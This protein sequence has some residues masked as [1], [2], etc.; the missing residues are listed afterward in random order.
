MEREGRE[1]VIENP[2]I[3]HPIHDEVIRL[4]KNELRRHNYESCLDVGSGNCVLAYRL[5][6][7]KI[8]PKIH[9]VDV[10]DIPKQFKNCSEFEHIK[11]DLNKSFLTIRIK[12]KFKLILCVEV[13]EHVENQF[14][15]M[16][17]LFG[18]LE[19]DGTLIITTPNI[20]S[21][22]SKLSF[23][24]KNTFTMFSNKNYQSSQHL[25]IN[26]VIENIFL[27]YANEIGLKLVN[28]SYSAG[29]IPKTNW[30]IPSFN[31]PLLGD[32]TIYIFE[33]R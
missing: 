14:K 5:I 22:W 23:L 7:E 15:L 33:K 19:D 21:L 10:V 8:V 4:L 26:P 1:E 27:I 2:I 17:E 20:Y 18:L 31:S 12:Q 28:K 9:T 30:I 24:K 3:N 16:R 25:H 29:H 13:I 32:S 6:T 11:L